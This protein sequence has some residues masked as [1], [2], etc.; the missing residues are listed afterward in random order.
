MQSICPESRAVAVSAA[1]E[2]QRAARKTKK[3]LQVL[4]ASLSLGSPGSIHTA[5]GS[6]EML[7]GTWRTDNIPE[8]HFWP[9]NKDAQP[10]HEQI[11]SV[12][13]SISKHYEEILY[14]YLKNT[15]RSRHQK[16]T[17]RRA[18]FTL[19]N[20]FIRKQLR[21]TARQHNSA[22]SKPERCYDLV[23]PKHSQDA[24][25]VSTFPEEPMKGWRPGFVGADV[26][27]CFKA[28][29]WEQAAVQKVNYLQ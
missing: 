18:D 4:P 29:K 26:R 2:P 14:E 15:A 25:C 1:F 16:Q 6:H 13:K 23:F 8:P 28:Q 24:H 10:N 9:R 7:K 11:C 12:G 19:C 17:G 3:W 22:E 27:R 20:Y 5:H 21:E